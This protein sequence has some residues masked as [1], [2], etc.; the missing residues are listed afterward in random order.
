M[1]DRLAAREHLGR[2]LL[3]GEVP[4]DGPELALHVKGEAVVNPP[5]LP[6]E[7]DDEMAAL[8]V[9]VVE[10]EIERGYPPE[11]RVVERLVQKSE[12][13]LGEISIDEPLHRPLAVRCFLPQYRLGNDAEGECRG[14]L[15][16]SDLAA[17]QA[18]GVIPQG[19]L[20]PP[21]L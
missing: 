20:A 21:G 3:T 15:V 9:A 12:V 1:N 19:A 16:G 13:V 11:L 8:T 7:S 18:P 4:H 2:Q 6:S 10:E 17:E 5:D 14:E